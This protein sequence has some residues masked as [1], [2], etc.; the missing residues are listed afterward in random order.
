MK[1]LLCSSE[2]PLHAIVE[3]A[4]RLGAPCLLLSPEAMRGKTGLELEAAFH[5]AARAFEEKSNISSKLSNE[6]LLFLAREMNFASALRRVGAKDAR[7]FV[8]VCEKNVPLARVKKEL[9]LTTAKRIALSRMGKKK[10]VYFE[11]E[12]AVEQL[13][14]ARVRN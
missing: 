3:A 12:L 1:V 5:L 4:E 6:A 8:L 11:G 9:G 7:A 2:K 14:L 10:G 13:A